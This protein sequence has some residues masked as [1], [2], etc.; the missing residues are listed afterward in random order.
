MVASK[1]RDVAFIVLMAGPGVSGEEILYRQGQDVLKT[2]GV[3]EK[4]LAQQRVIQERLFAA[5]KEDNDRTATEKKL[6]EIIAQETDKLSEEDKKKA[7]SQKSIV[8]GQIKNL[9]LTPWM[10]YFLTFDPQATLGLVRCPVLAIN[11]AK[12]VQVA[13][14]VNLLAIEK[15]LRAGGNRDVTVQEL[16][17]LNH[18][19][20][21]AKS[22]AVSEYGQIEETISPTALALMG[23]WIERRA[24]RPQVDSSVRTESLIEEGSPPRLLGRLR[25]RLLPLRL[26]N[27]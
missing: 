16:P 2:M 19:F 26:R 18:L 17:N 27:R 23:D 15:A 5:L 14:D 24:N 20:Q 9:L 4:Q 22:G 3:G 6:R 11:G 10:R 12:D 1:S 21:T 8:E 25:S 7:E 13:A